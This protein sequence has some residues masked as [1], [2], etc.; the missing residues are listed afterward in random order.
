MGLPAWP[1]AARPASSFRAAG[2]LTVLCPCAAAGPEEPGG[3]P[4]CRGL[5]DFEPENQGE[6]GFKEGDI[7]ALTGQID[8]NWYEGE[9]RGESGFFP[10]SYVEVVVPLPP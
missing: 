6:L 8:E 9:A 7:I 4:C 3:R 2:R 1:G 10:V 5:Y